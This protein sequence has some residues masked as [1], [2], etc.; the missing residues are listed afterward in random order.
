VS[1]P[2]A[3]LR[4][5]FGIFFWKRNL[6]SFTTDTNVTLCECICVIFFK[7]KRDMPRPIARGCW[8]E[9][10]R[11]RTNAR[12]SANLWREFFF[13][14]FLLKKEMCCVFFIS[15]IRTFSSHR[16]WFRLKRPVNSKK[17]LTLVW[18]C[19]LVSRTNTPQTS[20]CWSYREEEK[21]AS[22]RLLFRVKKW[23]DGNCI[24][25]FC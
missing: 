15:S 3:Y 8:R 13:F 18:L 24:F 25:V 14:L 21:N 1:T 11:A 5:L 6:F 12:A 4:Y 7:L 22:F 19:V 16:I 10:A 2:S 17:E 23:R 9:R 20:I